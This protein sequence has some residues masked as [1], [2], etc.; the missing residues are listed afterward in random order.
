MQKRNPKILCLYAADFVPSEPL[1]SLNGTEIGFSY[2]VLPSSP[3]PKGNIMS[4]IHWASNYALSVGGLEKLYIVCHAQ[5]PY[6]QIGAPGIN[7][8]NVEEIGRVL[9]GKVKVIDMYCCDLANSPEF[10]RKL[11]AASRATVKA[12]PIKVLAWPILYSASAPLYF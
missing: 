5:G 7:P 2:G 3:N 6:L 1:T 4:V 12:Y 11:A 10:C 8:W 9:K